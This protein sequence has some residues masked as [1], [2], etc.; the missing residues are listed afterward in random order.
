MKTS[1]LFTDPATG[2]L[3]T[4]NNRDLAVLTVGIE[5]IQELP[6][7]EIEY[8]EILTTGEGE[9]AIIKA[10]FVTDTDTRPTFEFHPKFVLSPVVATPIEDDPDT[11]GIRM[12]IIKSGFYKRCDIDNV[13]LGDYIAM[14]LNVEAERI[15][16]RMNEEL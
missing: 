16:D 9:D 7:I 2:N 3:T 10:M 1:Y 8:H 5:N 13:P 11:W 14:E 12:I 6:H 4:T 15:C